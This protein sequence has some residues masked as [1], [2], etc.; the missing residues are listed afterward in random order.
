MDASLPA[1][2][3][4]TI[5]Q[6]IDNFCDKNMNTSDV[7]CCIAVFRIYRFEMS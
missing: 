2:V 5:S 1:R 4:T 7:T 6:P 3:P